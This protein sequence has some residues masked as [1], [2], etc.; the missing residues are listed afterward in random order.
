MIAPT[1]RSGF[2]AIGT[3]PRHS[4]PPSTRCQHR[5][6]MALTGHRAPGYSTRP[7]SSVFPLDFYPLW[8]FLMRSISLLA[9]LFCSCAVVRAEEPSLLPGDA[10]A[11]ALEFK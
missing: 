6:R 5:G 2:H 11:V 9:I 1:G 3:R 4:L 7:F 8:S 10:P